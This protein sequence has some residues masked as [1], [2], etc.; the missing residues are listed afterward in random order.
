VHV[1]LEG[2]IDQGLEDELPCT[3]DHSLADLLV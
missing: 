3:A 2:F 1:E